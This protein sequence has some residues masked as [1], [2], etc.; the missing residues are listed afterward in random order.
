VVPS[1]D[2]S[3]VRT[4]AARQITSY[5]TVGAYAEFQKWLGR[6][7]AL[8]PMWDAWDSGDRARAVDLV[9]DEVVDDL[10][11]WGTPQQI[12]ARVER[13]AEHGVTTTAPAILSGPDQARATIRAL[14]PTP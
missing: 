10:I 5:L 12:R 4:F 6:G 8:T 1:N 3:A 9:P 11:V 14:A 13:Y 2:F 7:P